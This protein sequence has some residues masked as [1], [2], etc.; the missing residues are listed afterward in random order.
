[1]PWLRER[2]GARVASSAHWL[3]PRG[4]APRHVTAKHFIKKIGGRSTAP[5]DRPKAPS[6]S[7]GPKRGIKLE[8]AGPGPAG[9]TKPSDRQTNLKTRAAPSYSLGGKVS[10]SDETAGPGPQKH[11]ND[12]KR[13]GDKTA[14]T[15]VMIW[16]PKSTMAHPWTRH[17]LP[18]V[19]PFIIYLL[20]LVLA[21]SWLKNFS[22]SVPNFRCKVT[23]RPQA[24]GRQSSTQAR[25]GP[26]P[27]S[28]CRTFTR[29]RRPCV[30]RRR[31]R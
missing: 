21:E 19:A 31:S 23:T 20:V 18:V 10:W 5:I 17:G 1:M 22:K 8:T 28:T 27:S 9:Y 11:A 6:F 15:A 25:S 3:Q 12:A 26:T 13:P 16:K 2:L 24:P 4:S 7:L 29:G 30:L 14:P